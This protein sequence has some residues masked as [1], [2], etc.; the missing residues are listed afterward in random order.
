VTVCRKTYTRQTFIKR[1][2]IDRPLQFYLSI[3][4]ETSEKRTL[5]VT[6]FCPLFRG[7]TFK[8]YSYNNVVCMYVPMYNVITRYLL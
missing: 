1:V 7:D 4:S 2:E 6:K 3:Y 8:M 5:S